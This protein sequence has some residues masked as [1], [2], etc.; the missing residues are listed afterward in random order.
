ML[1]VQL[2]RAGDDTVT[3]RF[4]YKD[5]FALTRPSEDRLSVA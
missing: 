1:L 2:S 4:L 5:H 3:A